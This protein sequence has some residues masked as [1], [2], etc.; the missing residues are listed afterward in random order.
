MIGADLSFVT[1]GRSL[2]VAKGF[3]PLRR[4][5]NISDTE[6]ETWR[7][8][9]EGACLVALLTQGKEALMYH[10]TATPVKKKQNI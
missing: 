5:G 8:S 6:K 10:L 1:V 4:K 7:S 3:P 2:T 9:A